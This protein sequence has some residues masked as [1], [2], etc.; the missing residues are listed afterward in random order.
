MINLVEELQKH[1]NLEI[2][3]LYMYGDDPE[4]IKINGSKY[5]FPFK[6][7]PIL[8]GLQPDLIYIH[9]NW[10]FLL[11][12]VISKKLWGTKLVTTEHSH[13]VELP[14]IGKILMQYLF[15]SCDVITYVSRDLREKIYQVQA[16]PINVREEITYAGVKPLHV[17]DSEILNFKTQYRI[18]K[19]SF[20]LLMQ[21]S[22]IAKVKA[23]GT[24][25]LMQAIQG[26]LPQYPE[27]ILVITGDGPYL[28]VLEQY[29]VTHGIQ[30]NVVFTGWIDNPFVPITICDIYTHIS[31]G[32]GLPLA[33]VGSDVHR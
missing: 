11:A 17:S 9:N 1:S 23:D 27:I 24:K 4:N 15:K 31:L 14:Y 30:D 2:S 3:V 10:Y 16:I 19:T 8:Y 12:G 26:L 13:P 20:V 29:A 33:T 21:S 6:A 25:I 5:K 32:E 28:S 18:Q 22:P 7:I